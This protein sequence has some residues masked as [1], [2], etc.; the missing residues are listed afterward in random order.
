ML[1]SVIMANYNYAKYIEKAIS[2]VIHQT[3]QDVEL[4]IIDDGS[5]DDSWEIISKY[6]EIYSEKITAI[7]QKNSGQ[8]DSFNKGFKHAK[9]DIICFLDSD[10]YWEKNKLEVIKDIF[11]KNHNISIIQHNL[12]LIKDETPTKHLYAKQLFHGDY[13]SKTKKSGELPGFMPTSALS[14][15]RKALKEVFPLPIVFKTCADGYLARTSFCFGNVHVL[16][17][18][19]GYYRLHAANCVFNNQNHNNDYYLHKMLLPSLN[20]FYRKNKIEIRYNIDKNKTLIEIAQEKFK[21]RGEYKTKIYR[22]FNKKM[23][24]MGIIFDGS[25][26]YLYN[27][28]K[29][30]SNSKCYILGRS[31]INS[32]FNL[33]EIKNE[34]VFI[35]D[36]LI[37]HLDIGCF[38]NGIYCIS[39]SRLWM[40]KNN[41]EYLF[42]KL[43]KIP[44]MLKL[45]EYS[46]KSILEK[47]WIRDN[48]IIFRYINRNHKLWMNNFENDFNEECCWGDHVVLD[49]CLPLALHLGFQ[50][51]V[52]LGCEWE[53][54]IEKNALYN[55]HE[56]FLP[57]I[58]KDKTFPI[59]NGQLMREKIW[60]DSFDTINKSFLKNNRKIEFIAIE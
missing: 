29:E 31:L 36:C 22:H 15:S 14:F 49:F 5:T 52:M 11:C 59:M 27:L 17:N 40:E 39:D 6:K 53:Y 34:F 24:D 21:N 32:G 19:L 16:E 4:I 51:V 10:D 58:S 55:F 2:S 8:A 56:L 23:L 41:G 54:E 33:K 42:S 20:S 37:N 18:S 26:K 25:E 44:N 7:K 46:A 60:Q 43:G 48:K 12:Y 47:K 45:L 28:K 35:P 50:K 1:I 38:N 30:K 3:Y 13:F 57:N 9:G